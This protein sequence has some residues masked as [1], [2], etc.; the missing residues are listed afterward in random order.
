[1]K[2]A[3]TTP[4]ASFRQATAGAVYALTWSPGGERLVWGGGHL[5]GF[6]FIACAAGGEVVA[7]SDPY[8]W[9][10]RVASGLCFDARGTH[11]AVSTWRDGLLYQVTGGALT[12][13][14]T[15]CSPSDDGPMARAKATGVLL[16]EGWLIVRRTTAHPDTNFL[17]SRLP[18]GIHIDTG[19]QHLRSARVVGLPGALVT[20]IDEH[21]WHPSGVLV[22]PLD[23]AGLGEPR[24]LTNP[25]ALEGSPKASA[26]R[27]LP[28]D[29]FPDE[30]MHVILGVR[31]APRGEVSAIA[32]DRT[33]QRIVTC[34]TDGSI[35]TWSTSD[36]S[37]LRKR[38]GHAFPIAAACHVEPSGQLVTGDRSGL[39][40]VWEG[41]TVIA[42]WTVHDA[43]V[44]S[45]AAH[46]TEPRIAVGSKSLVDYPAGRVEVFDLP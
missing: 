41:D 13:E 4:V 33:G 40:R 43:S 32:I 27:A 30:S 31:A 44:R 36:L 6:G 19:G 15:L 29:R 34:G 28:L 16:H 12:D 2:K 9:R 42:E 25:H 22:V 20:G 11:L 5:D 37:R 24:V 26:H 46:P 38:P 18:A 8:A 35:G 1:M 10:N 14:T 39:V 3:P 17:L 45:L 7:W 21:F 23:D